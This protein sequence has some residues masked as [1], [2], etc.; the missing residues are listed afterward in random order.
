MHLLS[1]MPR[2]SFNCLVDK[3][4]IIL[5]ISKVFHYYVTVSSKT[6]HLAAKLIFHYGAVKQEKSPNGDFQFISP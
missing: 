2:L 1:Y 6:D 5:C 3:A 4:I